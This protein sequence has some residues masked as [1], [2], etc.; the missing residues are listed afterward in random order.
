MPA[1]WIEQFGKADLRSPR[2]SYGALLSLLPSSALEMSLLCSPSGC[3]P[4]RP[5][6]SSELCCC[7]SVCVCLGP[8]EGGDLLKSIQIH[9]VSFHASFWVS[10]KRGWRLFGDIYCNEFWKA[11]FR[12][13]VMCRQWR[14]LCDMDH[15]QTFSCLSP[16]SSLTPPSWEDP[17]KHH[18]L[19]KT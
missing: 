12:R 1:V 17:F 16:H 11:V 5:R 9:P 15:S 13:L 10:P 7:W 6:L 4:L 14:V 3:K 18:R 8:Q 2:N 19:S